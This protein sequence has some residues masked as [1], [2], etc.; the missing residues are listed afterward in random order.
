MELEIKGYIEMC[1]FLSTNPTI[2]S[3][4]KELQGILDFCF[5][6]LS[7]CKC[8]QKQKA[9][10]TENAYMEKMLQL[11]DEA[12][13]F[14]LGIINPKNEYSSITLSFVDSDKIIKLK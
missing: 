10:Q 5:Y 3:Q 7:G 9:K 14:L 1:R 2:I 12:K 6:S 8:S 11:G 4:N 13:A